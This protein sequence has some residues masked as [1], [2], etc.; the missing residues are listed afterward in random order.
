MKC[1]T[2]DDE[3]IV[4]V[5]NNSSLAGC[6][7]DMTLAAKGANYSTLK[8]RIVK[9]GI[10]ISHFTGQGHKK[11]YNRRK[12]SNEE[13]FIEN[14][15]SITAVVRNRILKDNLLPYECSEPKCKLK[16][17]LN[18]DI[19]LH[20]DHVNGIDNDHRL[21]NLRFL[22]PNCHSQTDTYCGKN[23][24]LKNIQNGNITT[25]EDIKEAIRKVN[26]KNKCL[27]CDALVYKDS[28]R[29]RKCSDKIP[30][31]FIRAAI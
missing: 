28:V 3:L 21:E 24:R 22:C 14:S 9:L 15:T 20:L 11:G 27:N 13:L 7:R 18:K 12:L 25:K 23:K 26:F 31:G 2:S 4:I 5:K 29:C 10:D 16:E 17:W 19:S 30:K 6:L 1:R 8:R